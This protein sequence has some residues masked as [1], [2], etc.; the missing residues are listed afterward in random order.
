[1]FK[2][3]NF[4][5]CFHELDVKLFLLDNA[6]LRCNC[7]DSDFNE[8]YHQHILAGDLSSYWCNQQV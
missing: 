2:I 8:K 5:K 6:I 4:D 3:S 1:M 7:A